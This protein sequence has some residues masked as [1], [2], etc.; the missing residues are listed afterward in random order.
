MRWRDEPK[1][2]RMSWNTFWFWNFWNPKKILKLEKNCCTTNYE[3]KMTAQ[4]LPITHGLR[5]GHTELTEILSVSDIGNKWLGNPFKNR[6]VQCGH[7]C[8]FLCKPNLSET[9][10][11]SERI[12]V[13]S[14]WPGRYGQL[15]CENFYRKKRSFNGI[16][17][18]TLTVRS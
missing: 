18:P 4:F 6:S 10:S 9:K 3:R 5:L 1:L 13:S 15:L 14:V 12:S 16:H 17:R 7:F 8:I 2:L 11:D